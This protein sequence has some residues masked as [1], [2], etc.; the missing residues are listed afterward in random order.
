[1]A[2]KRIKEIRM[3]VFEYARENS[4]SERF[5]DWRLNNPEGFVVN[6]KGKN[7]AMLHRA[8]CGHFEFKR[9][10]NLAASQKACSLDRK[11]VEE[12]ASSEGISQL[13]LCSDCSL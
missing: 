9:K 2:Y 12:W 11:Q 5:L 3:E 10:V 8:K 6:Y 1:M 13:K 4:A 7:N